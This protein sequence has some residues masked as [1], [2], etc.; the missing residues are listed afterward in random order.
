M[1]HFEQN[2]LSPLLK[3]GPVGLIFENNLSMIIGIQEGRLLWS[4]DQRVPTPHRW[5]TLFPFFLAARVSNK[6]DGPVYVYDDEI[7]N[8]L[9]LSLPLKRG[10]AIRIFENNLSTIIGIQECRLLWSWD[11]TVPTTHIV[12][13]ISLIRVSDYLHCC[14]FNVI[15]T[16]RYCEINKSYMCC[17]IIW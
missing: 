7:K 8:Q 4:T 9:S 11:Q 3:R 14:V 10:S 6:I 5:A 15:S 2:W 12:Y 13:Q 16:N 17:W 1:R